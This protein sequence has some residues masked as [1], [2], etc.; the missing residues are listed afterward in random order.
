[1]TV[2]EAMVKVAEEIAREEGY[3]CVYEPYKHYARKDSFWGN[4]YAAV[5]ANNLDLHIITTKW[6]RPA[7]EGER[8]YRID[9][10][11]YFGEPRLNIQL[12]GGSAHL[13]YKEGKLSETQCFGEDALMLAAY[14]KERIDYYLTKE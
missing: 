14:Y 5:K 10:D 3:I 7:F 8:V 9:I 4:Q 11:M 13:T 12:P 6:I 2:N 1:M